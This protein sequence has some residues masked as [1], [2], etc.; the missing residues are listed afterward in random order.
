MSGDE[1][2][3]QTLEAR[4]MRTRL[5]ELNHGVGRS[6]QNPGVLPASVNPDSKVDNCKQNTHVDASED[7]GEMND[8]GDI[9]PPLLKGGDDVD[10][11]EDIGVQLE[12]GQL[13]YHMSE[14]TA[15]RQHVQAV[16]A[17]ITNVIEIFFTVQVEV[18]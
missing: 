9:F 1:T 11:A 15:K 16:G 5:K 17:S 3:R 13:S 2:M 6:Q 4:D 8:S 12:S 10:A 14:P 7:G 18:C